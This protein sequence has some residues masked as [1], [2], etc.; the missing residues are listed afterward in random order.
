MRRPFT[1]LLGAEAGRLETVPGFGYRWYAEAPGYRH[2]CPGNPMPAVKP[3]EHIQ[4]PD[5]KLDWWDKRAVPRLMNFAAK[6]H[7]YSIHVL[8][9]LGPAAAEAVPTL[10]TLL[11]ESPK[12]ELRRRAAQALGRIGP[13]S[14]PAVP[15]LIQALQ[16]DSLQVAQCAAEA[17]GRIG[18]PAAAA[19]IRAALKAG[20]LDP[21]TATLAIWRIR[22][23]P[24]PPATQPGRKAGSP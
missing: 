18:D 4:A 3:G 16:K 21:R 19:P 14:K 13:A 24:T 7:Q 17:L 20:R 2:D 11:R 10:I 9:K 1:A 15:A 5:V 22:A 12:G 23:A 6:G 8:G